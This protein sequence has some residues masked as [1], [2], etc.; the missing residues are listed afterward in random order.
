MIDQIDPLLL[1]MV[2]HLLSP[3]RNSRKITHAGFEGLEIFESSIGNV[4]VLGGN[5][6]QPAISRGQGL[7][8]ERALSGALGESLERHGATCRPYLSKIISGSWAGLNN[9]YPL[10]DL[11]S[12]RL[13]SREQILSP[14]FDLRNV[15]P[16]DSI[17]WIQGFLFEG[18]EPGEPGE[19]TEIYFPYP[20]VSLNSNIVGEYE[21]STTNGIALGSS[22]TAARQ[23]ALCEFIERAAF[24]ETWWLKKSPDVFTFQDCLALPSPSIQ[25]CAQWLKDR[26]FV[27]DLSET[28]GVPTFACAIRGRGF[29]EPAFTLSAAAAPSPLSAFQKCIEET[30]RIF[31]D[32]V[33]YIEHLGHIGTERKIPQPPYEKSIQSFADIN[34]LYSDPKTRDW[35]AFLFAGAHPGEKALAARLKLPPISPEAE[36]IKRGGRILLFDITPIDLAQAGLSLIRAIV[37]DAVPLNATHHGRPWG[38]PRLRSYSF[39]DLN[40]MPHPFP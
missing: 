13:Y 18:E 27:L 1:R 24:L 10:F 33:D 38:C 37:P 4:K 12:T 21:V 36:V 31:L 25:L 8:A 40:Q 22:L 26:L 17:D 11:E 23:S 5:V 35:T 16:H 34:A 7:R 14:E 28:W 30:T 9:R 6:V 32:H 20:R 29:N 15:E 19:P 3:I 39:A 2:G